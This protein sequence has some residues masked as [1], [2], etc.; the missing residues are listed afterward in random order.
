MYIPIMITQFEVT[1]STLH[2]GKDMMVAQVAY[3]GNGGEIISRTLFTE[4][5]TLISTIKGTESELPHYTKITRKRDGYFYFIKL[6][7]KE[8]QIL[9]LI[10][11]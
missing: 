7:E 10:N 6:N 3:I 11:I 8:K 4:S 2:P 5:Y 9:G 1:S